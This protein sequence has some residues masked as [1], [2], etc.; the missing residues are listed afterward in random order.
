LFCFLKVVGG[1]ISEYL[2]EKSRVAFQNEDELNFHIFYYLLAGLEE[3]N[4]KYFLINE[5]KKDIEFNYL[6]NVT[7]RQTFSDDQVSHFKDKYDELINAMDYVA[8]MDDEKIELFS[9]LVGILHVGNLTFVSNDE[10]YATFV[11]SKE[12]QFSSMAIAKLIG[13]NSDKLIE[14]LT[15]MQPTAG[16]R[17]E[18]VRNHTL[19]A[20]LDARDALA[21]HVYLKLFSWIVAKIN[22]TILYSDTN[23][24]N[25]VGGHINRIGILDIYGFEHFE[26]NN[27]E[28]LCINLAN[29][30][31]Q[32]FF[33]KHIFSLEK[34]E[35]KREGIESISITFN[36]NQLLLDLFM[37]SSGILKKLD[38]LCKLPKTTKN[39]LIEN[40]NKEFGK[41]QYY[42]T[43]KRNDYNFAICHYAGKVVYTCENFLEKNR[44]SL[45]YR[46][47]EL[48]R[49][50]NNE[51]LREIF[52]VKNKF[53]DIYQT[54]TSVKLKFF[55]SLL[56]LKLFLLIYFKGNYEIFR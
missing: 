50:S 8:F 35:Y 5:S 42:V 4:D 49:N 28:Q 19:E 15:T 44:D 26:K 14:A 27:F 45:P 38:D 20:A 16:G 46:V 10:G 23:S 29:E 51:I 31:I 41:N 48:L 9:T 1:K 33:N 2:L 39:S 47:S 55:M 30:Q 18:F 17:D 40:F 21:K 22:E 25:S 54:Y 52:S 12:T 24:D 11:D 32:Y 6:N 36:D 7:L 56:L 13:I 43:S 34:E 53:S 37:G 3:M